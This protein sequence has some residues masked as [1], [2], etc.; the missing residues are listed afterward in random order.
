MSTNENYFKIK[1][2]LQFDDGSNLTSTNV[3]LTANSSGTTATFASVILIPVASSSGAAPTLLAHFDT[4]ITDATGTFTFTAE[5]G[6][7]ISTSHSKFGTG[8]LHLPSGSDLAIDNNSSLA[9]GTNDYT[10]ECWL[11]AVNFGAGGNFSVFSLNTDTPYGNPA[12]NVLALYSPGSTSD[13]QVANYLDGSN[14]ST[15][16]YGSVNNWYHIAM[17]RQGTSVYVA[18]NGQVTGGITNGSN[19]TDINSARI[20][21]DYYSEYGCEIYIN[22]F[23]VTKG[24]AL[25]TS[26]YTPPS[27]PFSYGTGSLPAGVPGKLITISGSGKLAY[28]DVTNSR[29]SYVN[30]GSAV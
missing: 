17:C 24:T 3:L 27:A 26:T 20:H 8:S 1:K 2:G 10:V 15:S 22:E 14:I 21:T 13:F 23:R 25:Y 12:F 5:G 30:D 19:F 29:W 11:Y 18:L 28:W 7:G 16:N 6:A 4:D 9:F